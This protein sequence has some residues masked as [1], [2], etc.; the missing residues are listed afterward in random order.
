MIPYSRPKP[1]NLYTLSKSKRL[2]NHTL[3]SGIYL[4]SP[5]MAVPPHPGGGGGKQVDL[6][7]NA[8]FLV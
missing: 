2:E 6:V 5:H 3:H 7:K 1:S 4:Y 8:V